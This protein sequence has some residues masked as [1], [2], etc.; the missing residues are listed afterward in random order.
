MFRCGIQF[1]KD[2]W[3]FIWNLVFY[4]NQEHNL[5]LISESDP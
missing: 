3:F 2:I 5:F 4:L 1:I